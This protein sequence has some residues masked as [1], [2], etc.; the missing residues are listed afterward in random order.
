MSREKYFGEKSEDGFPAP[1]TIHEY[2]N[3]QVLEYKNSFVAHCVSC[4]NWYR[5]YATLRSAISALNGH[6]RWA[7]EGAIPDWAKD[8]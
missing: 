4:D 2:E 1:R 6:Y 3:G 5:S 8:L 7:H